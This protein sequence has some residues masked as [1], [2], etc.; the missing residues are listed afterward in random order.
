MDVPGKRWK[1]RPRTPRHVLKLD[2][3]QSTPRPTKPTRPTGPPDP[4][5]H[6]TNRANNAKTHDEKPWETMRNGEKQWE[7]VRN[8]K[9]R[10]ETVRN[11]QHQ[12]VSSISASA[13]SA[14]SAHQQYRRL[15]S[16]SSWAMSIINVSEPS[17]H[18]QDQGSSSI[19][20]SESSASAH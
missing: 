11:W 14:A 6:Q 19:R 20:I 17:M 9:K 13:A 15:S 3:Y 4:R 1:T 12:S 2:F 10:Q 5:A 8:R 18:Q 16:I 7:T